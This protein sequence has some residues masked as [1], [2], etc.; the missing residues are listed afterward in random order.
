MREA[1]ELNLDLRGALQQAH[2]RI[3]RLSN[4]APRSPASPQLS[5]AS[6]DASVVADLSLKVVAWQA[7]HE[8]SEAARIQTSGECAQLAAEGAR[9]NLVVRSLMQQL[10]AQAELQQ[11]RAPSSMALMFS[12]AFSSGRR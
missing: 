7:R 8:E 4:A 2:L 6:V 1:R 12:R 3:Q 9:L 11:A 5:T 10:E